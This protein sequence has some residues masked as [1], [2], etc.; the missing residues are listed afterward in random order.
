[1][2]PRMVRLL[3]DRYYA[4][5]SLH[6]CD[7]VTGDAV[8]LDDL[9]ADDTPSHEPAL[10]PF[11]EVLNHG[12][13]GDPR[14]VVA[15]A[16]NG[17]QASALV[18]RAAAHARRT[19]YV[20]IRV[21]LYERLRESL[22]DDLGERSLL[23]IGTFADAGDTARK[24]FVDAAAHSPRPHVLLT[25]ES[26][27]SRDRGVVRE[28]RAVYGTA[29]L[30]P[31]SRVQAVSPDVARHLQ[32]GARAT[33]FQCAGRHAA[34]ERLLRDVAAALG[35]REAFDHAATTMIALA[36]MLLE[37]GR[38]RDA[39]AT[40]DE[41]ARL[42]ERGHSSHVAADARIWQ[43]ACRT[44]DA[45]LTDAEAP[46]RALL[47]TG[48]LSRAQR[49]LASALLARVLLW[50]RR[51]DDAVQI[52]L[53][54]K[55][56]SPADA[57]GSEIEPTSA[58]WAEATEV[59]VLVTAGRLFEAGRRVTALVAR[60]EQ[61]ADVMPRLIANVARL[62]HL[63]AV[64][65]LAGG[66]Q[67][68]HC[69]LTLAR[70]V[71]A[72][73]RA[74]RVRLMWHDVLRRVDRSREAQAQLDRLRRLR[75][76]CPPLLRRAIDERLS[77]PRNPSASA[78]SWTSVQA[79]APVALALLN[80]AHE[81]EDDGNAVR[82]TLDRL[83]GELQT[84]RI[85]MVSTDAGPVST[86]LSIGTGLS[87]HLGQR[88]LETGLSLP[89]EIHR[90]GKEIGTPIRL[91]SRLLSA[92]VCRWP[93]D[94]EPPAGA[95]DM[96]RLAAAVV[97]PRVDAL[98]A[99]ARETARAATS[100]PELVGSSKTMAEMRRAIERAAT[101]PFSVLI[102]GESGVGKELVARAIHQL[103][104]RRERR[105]CD[106]NCA[107]LPD[108]LLDSELFGHARGAFTGA[109]TDRAGLFEDAD[110]GTVF[111]DE[112]P[113]LSAR[114]QAKL[115]RV[116]QQHEVRRIGETFSR[117]VDVRLVTA[118]NRDMAI[119]VAEGRFR[120]DLLYRVD[121]IRIRIP[122][123]RDR[124]DDIAAL[125]DH[126]WRSAAGRVGSRA[127]LTPAVITALTRYH[128]PGNVRELQNVMAALAVSSRR[129]VDAR[130]QFERRWV[131]VALA[132]A[133]G[134]R[135][136][137]AAELGL[138]RQGLLKMMTRLGLE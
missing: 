17:V 82:Q 21:D 124:P 73:L 33:E 113:D 74:V 68:F 119:E 96:L 1:M 45:R 137:A 79:G 116:L 34:A 132:R 69:I 115:L 83:A 24:V 125:T 78:V 23:L 104:P 28:A 111:L 29:P 92:L 50:Q 47:L 97:A 43:A 100:V 135:T 35:R 19:G 112:L 103:G 14:W 91:G 108:E 2:G 20:P 58:A 39:E 138:S 38:A 36:R 71:R 56:D 102:E 98:L 66:E 121:V 59:R 130:A 22:N 88:V 5:D 46:V 106:V 122:P 117:K 4:Y 55:A 60:T 109:V 18:R 120:R 86:L 32:R 53:P 26:R 11:V 77:E 30:R 95:L 85:E 126:F 136:R 123:L 57:D 27:Q 127:T 105:F 16:R 12:R 93:L 31:T 51:H 128:W 129:L 65:D 134:S 81:E 89:C 101:A 37:R 49:T 25:F 61:N 63:A 40:C 72:S 110:G 75:S 52:V 15:D 54:R 76:A 6:G 67:C 41:A 48:A 10:A 90:G 87:T 84:C 7:L 62:R 44:D 80:A 70:E 133:G 13:E 118:T 42:A 94:R 8:R 99:S 131:E 3:R 107:A 9:P 114:G 64:G